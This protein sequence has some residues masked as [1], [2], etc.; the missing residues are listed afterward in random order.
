MKGIDKL[1]GKFDVVWFLNAHYYHRQALE[2]A[3]FDKFNIKVDLDVDSTPVEFVA[4]DEKLKLTTQRYVYDALTELEVW[5]TQIADMVQTEGRF[6]REEHTHKT[7]YRTHNVN[8]TPFPTRVYRSWKALFQYE[9]GPFVPPEA[10]LTGKT[11][12]VW[13]WIKENDGEFTTSDVA[14]DLDMSIAN[15][16]H[17]YLKHLL[18]INLIEIV[19]NGRR[20]RGHSTTLKI[21][22]NVGIATK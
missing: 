15:I 18:S 7:I 8:I 13:T 20:G 14:N 10:W 12:D 5:H 9:F 19:E 22:E 4:S 17:R 3:I 11:S 16:K 2:Q 21:A 6:L 1:N